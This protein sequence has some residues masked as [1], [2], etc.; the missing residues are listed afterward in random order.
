MTIDEFTQRAY[1][2]ALQGTIAGDPD[3]EYSLRQVSESVD[4]HAAAAQQWYEKHFTK[5]GHIKETG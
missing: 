5:S 2:A 4:E 1:L 3:G